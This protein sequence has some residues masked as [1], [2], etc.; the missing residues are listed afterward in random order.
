[1]NYNFR[2]KNFYKE[3][4]RSSAFRILPCV[5]LFFFCLLSSASF[6]QQIQS[7][8]DST[9][10][11]IGEQITYKI[12]IET[13]SI[14]FVVFPE[15][16]T[17]LPLEMIESY[18]VD[19]ARH[20]A[21]FRLIKRYGLTQ[22]DSGIYTIP[23]QKI[24]I[25]N[26]TIFTDSLTVEVNNI[27]V[28]TTKQ[29]LFDIK[30][31][32]EVDKS[33]SNWWLYVLIILIFL[34]IIAF[35]LY[36]FIWREKPLTK[37][38]KVA[39]LPPYERAKLA[40]QELDKSEYLQNEEI[41]E[42]YSEL[43]GII[44]TYLD[45]KVYDHSLESTT[46]ELISRLH[47]L[48]D[49]QQIDLSKED[50]STIENI[51]KRADLVKFA[52]SKPDIALAELD[53]NT[54]DLEIDHVK[55][56]LPEPTEEEKLLNQKYKEKQERK[57]KQRKIITTIIV[58][59]FLLFATVA[60]FIVKY[61]FE[62]VKD[63]II[64]HESK[65]LLEGNWVTSDYGFPPVTMNTP[66]VLERKD[67]EIPEEAKGK[68]RTTS[69]GYELDGKLSII[70]ITTVLNQKQKE[71]NAEIFIE[72]NLK[73]MENEGGKN[74]ITMYDEFVTPN[75]AEGVKTYGTL[76]LPKDKTNKDEYIKGKYQILVFISEGTIIQQIMMIWGNDDTYADQIIDRILNSIE[77]I[78]PEE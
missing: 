64:G 30:P 49:G 20:D 36:W 59:V 73:S 38:E 37:E 16:Q 65:E 19:T 5:I 8:I 72:R 7:S 76:E 34:G 55:E 15:G 35:L 44:R 70:V 18:Q 28:D 39:L 42:Y 62:Y 29:G 31:I 22:F 25:G 4:K 13:D 6:A 71:I 63:T 52:K 67:V 23:R 45:E 17:F 14:D 54:I 10:I 60:G 57:K 41:K 51:L 53:R 43:T 3:T 75:G 58:A 40:L 32:I 24:I 2:H 50:I 69:F 26:K 33:P 1:M 9:S 56:S 12:Q 74:I 78:K 47:L 68:T 11:K 66:K 46:E 27:V 21:K 48:K 77:L 61:G